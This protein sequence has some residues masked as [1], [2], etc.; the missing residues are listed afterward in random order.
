M[1]RRPSYHQEIHSLTEEVA[2]CKKIINEQKNQLNYHIQDKEKLKTTLKDY[3]LK[4]ERL[5]QENQN[6]QFKLQLHMNEKRLDNSGETISLSLNHSQSNNEET[7]TID[8][9]DQDPKIKFN[10]SLDEVNK[11][12]VESEAVTGDN[13]KEQIQRTATISESHINKA[14]LKLKRSGSIFGNMNSGKR[15]SSTDYREYIESITHKDKAE[16]MK[17]LFELCHPLENKLGNPAITSVEAGMKN[18]K[19]FG[20]DEFILK[21]DKTEEKKGFKSTI[22]EISFSMSSTEENP[23]TTLFNEFF[24]ITCEKKDI[25][26]YLKKNYIDFSFSYSKNKNRNLPISEEVINFFIPFKKRIVS[27]RILN[28]IGKL[29]Q[30]LF[31][32]DIKEKQS[33]FFSIT[34][35][36]NLSEENVSYIPDLLKESNPNLFFYYYCIKVDD[37]FI[38][39]ED[40]K[41]FTTDV[42]DFHFHPKYY[43]FKTFYPLSSFFQE[44][45]VGLLSNIRRK[46]IEKFMNCII[47]GKVD[48]QS[49]SLIDSHNICEIEKLSIELV[50]TQ[51]DNITGYDKFNNKISIQNNHLSIDY[52]T[53]IKKDASFVDCE[54]AFRNVFNNLCFEDFLFI[55][56]SIIHEKHVVFISEDINMSTGALSAFMSLMRPFK[57]SLPIIYNL[58]HELLPILGSPVPVLVGINQT[59]QFVLNKII[60]EIEND[61]ILYVFLDHGL[62]QFKLKLLSEVLLPQYDS[63]ISKAKKIY[64]KNFNSKNSN[65]IRLGYKT[66][67]KNT[68]YYL[69]KNNYDTLQEKFK[70]IA[71]DNDYKKKQNHHNNIKLKNNR[72][73]DKQSYSI[74]YLFRHLYDTFIIS[75]L[76]VDGEMLE[77]EDIIAIKHLDIEFF[78]TNPGDIDFLK[79]FVSKQCFIY[80]LEHEI[81]NNPDKSFYK[82]SDRVIRNDYN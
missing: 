3:L 78:S 77:N 40:M 30:L 53:P 5:K 69:K 60:P 12:L 81:Y 33:E 45:L 14:R 68:V 71:K 17:Y 54:F 19:F 38:K 15:I 27:K 58:P 74:F 46:R 6:L 49:L 52:T 21:D 22:N 1:E 2:R 34:L 18:K 47:G 42:I 13:Q 39:E 4:I 66:R 79:S 31:Q 73:D 16:R 26:S 75:K 57:W 50:L 8:R 80:F 35:T 20:G 61:D 29:N 23:L 43:I 51:L 24:I 9:F 72:N 48:I 41:D 62:I 37:F 25:D 7:R 63:F 10:E 64:G 44:V 67:N 11:R 55:Y 56:F 70:K 28:T 59:T 76:P 36:S 32:A 65:H 82:P